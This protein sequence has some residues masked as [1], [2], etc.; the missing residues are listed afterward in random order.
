MFFL[1]IF[2]EDIYWTNIVWFCKNHLIQ[3]QRICYMGVM[4]DLYIQ[5][6]VTFYIV[7]L[8]LITCEDLLNKLFIEQAV[9]FCKIYWKY[10]GI[11]P[12]TYWLTLLD[13]LVFIKGCQTVC[14]V[15]L[16]NY[17][18]IVRLYSKIAINYIG[19][20]LEWFMFFSVSNG[21][22]QAAQPQNMTVMS[23]KI[24]WFRYFPKMFMPR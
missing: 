24:Y 20:I 7:L 9:Q 6:C 12:F 2:C 21:N 13:D 15:P 5:F 23:R 19:F 14:R 22:I 3:I 11:G 8:V 16:W 1:S 10:P 17:H 18:N 4:A